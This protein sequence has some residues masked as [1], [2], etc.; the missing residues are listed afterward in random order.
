MERVSLSL[1]KAFSD[2]LYFKEGM[3]VL[4]VFAD[5]LRIGSTTR[6]ISL[7]EER[8]ATFSGRSRAIGSD[9]KNMIFGKGS[10]H[11]TRS[12]APPRIIFPHETLFVPLF[13]PMGMITRGAMRLLDPIMPIFDRLLRLLIHLDAF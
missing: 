3:G 2:T 13:F 8:S 9:G 7:V 11:P 10:S 5:P 12:L 6:R 1:G 4:F